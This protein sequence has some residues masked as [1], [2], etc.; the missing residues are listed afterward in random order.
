MFIIG[1][2]GGS[3]SPGRW[4][5]KFTWFLRGRFT[6]RRKVATS[7]DEMRRLEESEVVAYVKE[8]LERDGW[9]EASPEISPFQRDIVFVKG[10]EKYVIEAKGETKGGETHNIEVV[11]GQIVARMREGEKNVHYGI[12]IPYPYARF[13]SKFGLEGLRALNL[14]LFIVARI[15]WVW[16]LIPERVLAYVKEL[17][18]GMDEPD[19]LSSPP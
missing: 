15:G 17:R 6:W 12:A 1:E 7:E 10:G 16:H 19:L 3:G 13:L 4:A 5:Q 9:Q 2:S 18:K 11:I 8:F 14:H